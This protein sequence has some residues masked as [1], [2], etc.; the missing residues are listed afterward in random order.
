M[1]ETDKDRQRDSSV[2]DRQKKKKT[3]ES[4]TDKDRNRDSSVRDREADKAV[5]Y[6]QTETDSAVGDRWTGVSDRDK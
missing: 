5:S 2:R 6:R 3:E 4:E 1:S